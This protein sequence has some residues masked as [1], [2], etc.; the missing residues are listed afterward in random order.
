V[1]K[2]DIVVNKLLAWRGAIG[3]SKYE[4]VTS[5]AYDILRKINPMTDE[6]FFVYLFRTERA[7]QN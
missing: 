4:G 6:R 5:P 1:K 7:Q 2:G 3:L